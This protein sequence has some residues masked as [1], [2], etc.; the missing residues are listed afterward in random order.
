MP[1]GVAVRV[2][3]GVAALFRM[4]EGGVGL[5]AGGGL[6]PRATAVVG[7]AS[8]ATE[9][10]RKTECFIENLSEEPVFLK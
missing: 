2:G 4:G 6:V 5:G 1:V 10:S 7:R 3:V 9:P 8:W